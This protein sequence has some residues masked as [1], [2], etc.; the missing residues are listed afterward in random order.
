MR[1]FARPASWRSIVTDCAGSTIVE[2]A[3]VLPL[4]FACGFG[5][6]EVGRA[7]WIQ[8]SL[9]FA[10][11][12]AAR[13]A[14]INQVSCGTTA[15]I[16]SF[17]AARANVGAITASQFTVSTPACGRMVSVSYP[18]QSLV[19]DLVPISV[20]LTAQSCHPA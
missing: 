14:A 2:A 19:P 17:A 6:V 18:F 1:I 15:A 10:V 11:E 3:I 8:N 16:T 12:D 20:T 4:L 5:L 9:Q 13:C 7:L